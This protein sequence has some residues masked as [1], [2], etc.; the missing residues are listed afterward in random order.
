[1]VKGFLPTWRKHFAIQGCH[2]ISGTFIR[3]FASSQRLPEISVQIMRVQWPSLCGCIPGE[4]KNRN[5]LSL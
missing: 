4:F 1:M 3:G 5:Y 2:T